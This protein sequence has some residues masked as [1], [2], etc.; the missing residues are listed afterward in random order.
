MSPAEIY[1]AGLANTAATRELIERRRDS[2]TRDD[3]DRTLATFTKMDRAP[4][5][6]ALREA[7]REHDRLRRIIEAQRIFIES[8]ECAATPR[9]EA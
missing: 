5:I 8:S 7:Y 1:A 3:W 9:V 4:L 6:A 2:A